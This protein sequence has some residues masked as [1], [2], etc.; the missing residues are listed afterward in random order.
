[1]HLGGGLTGIILAP[2]FGVNGI[3]VDGEFIG[4]VI[5]GGRTEAYRVN[6]A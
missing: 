6:E 5:Y 3:E 4:G 1:M 2:I